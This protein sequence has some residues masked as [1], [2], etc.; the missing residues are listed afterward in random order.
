MT[1]ETAFTPTLSSLSDP[2]KAPIYHTAL[3]VLEHTGMTLQHEPAVNLLIDAGCHRDAQGRI[4]IPAAHAQ[5]PAGNPV[6]SE[7]A[8][9]PKLRTVVFG[10]PDHHFGSGP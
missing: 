8:L 2:D 5:T 6:A 10:R 7:I 4:A 9:P 3:Q 1:L